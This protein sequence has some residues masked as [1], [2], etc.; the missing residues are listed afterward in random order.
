MV[1]QLKFFEKKETYKLNQAYL[2]KKI[3][4]NA[5]SHKKNTLKFKQFM[6]T[7][8]LNH[9]NIFLRHHSWT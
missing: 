9:S 6:S 5:W 4:I 7:L 1:K 8:D 2:E 3:K